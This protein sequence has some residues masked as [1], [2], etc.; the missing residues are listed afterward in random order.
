MNQ[1]IRRYIKTFSNHYKTISFFLPSSANLSTKTTQNDTGT[2][3]EAKSSMIDRFLIKRGLRTAANQHQRLI[4]NPASSHTSSKVH[5]IGDGFQPNTPI[6]IQ[7]S[8]VCPD[9]GFDFQ[10]YAHI[11]A[12][13]DGC[14]DLKT[15]ESVGGTYQGVDEMGLFWSMVKRENAP[16]NRCILANGSRDLHYNFK[17]FLGH[18]TDDELEKESSISSTDCQRYVSRNV[19]RVPL[20]NGSVFGTLFLPEESANKTTT[21]VS[22]P[23]KLPVII[24]IT[25]GIKRG[26]VHEHFASFLA[27]HGFATLALAFFGVKGM[28]NKNYQD[29]PIKVEYFEEAVEFLQQCDDIDPERIGV[30]GLSKGGDLA[31]S[32]MAHLPQIKA[33]CHVNASIATLVTP[34]T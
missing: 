2:T 13:K 32:M 28:P 24:T 34:T 23:K 11:Y 17:A 22:T 18:I 1:I 26:N 20:E 5:I 19:K 7:S 14:F 10:S 27:H 15:T 21:V 31:L 25:G 9:E 12:D 33:V 4:V 8:L 30:F 3:T 29:S 6:T 16:F